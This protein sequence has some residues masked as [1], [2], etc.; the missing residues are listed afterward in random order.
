MKSQVLPVLH[1]TDLTGGLKTD[2]NTGG[3]AAAI[4][5]LRNLANQ[6]DSMVTPQENAEMNT[7]FSALDAF[8]DTPILYSSSGN[9][10]T[11]GSAGSG[12]TG[13]AGNS[14]SGNTGDTGNTR[15]RLPW[16]KLVPDWRDLAELAVVRGAPAHR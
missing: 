1:V 14:G 9:T 12:N 10:G 6:P 11:T 4:G 2:E 7:D 13:S 16:S 5:C 3:Y 8:F 15:G